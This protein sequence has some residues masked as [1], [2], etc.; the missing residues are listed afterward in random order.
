MIELNES[1]GF[2]DIITNKEFISESISTFIFNDN[3]ITNNYN[4]TFELNEKK[5]TVIDSNKEPNK[6]KSSSFILSFDNFAKKKRGRKSNIKVIKLHNK[7][8]IDNI[9]RKIQV[10][11]LNFIVTFINTILEILGFK[12]KLFYLNYN[13]KKNICKSNIKFL[14]NCT[15]REI[16]SNQISG[17]YK[18]V[19]KDENENILQT[20]I[21]CPIL[22]KILSEKYMYLSD[23]YLKSQRIINLDAYGLNKTIELPKKIEL[24]DDL[25]KKYT[26]E[27][28][29]EYLIRLKSCIQKYFY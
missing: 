10:H 13:L 17:K 4:R 20:I 16:L 9:L 27:E 21:N 7:F 25:L 2:N 29:N 22:K 28:N 8:T 14:K 11:Y 26:K 18:K 15:L 3:L 19:N 23:I 12:I 5:E 1:Y 6:D 24:F